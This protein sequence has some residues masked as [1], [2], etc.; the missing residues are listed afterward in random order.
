MLKPTAGLTAKH[1]KTYEQPSALFAL[2]RDPQTNR[3]FAGGMDGAIWV[4][5]GR[6]AKRSSRPSATPHANYLS[7]LA[8]AGD[9]VITGGFDREL[10]WTSLSDGKI[11]RRRHAHEG[12]VRDLAVF[13]DGTKIASAGMTCGSAFGTPRPGKPLTALKAIRSK[14]PRAM[15]RLYTRSPQAQ[16]ENTSPA[17]TA[18]A[19]CG[20]GTPKRGNFWSRSVPRSF[21][22]T[23]PKN[24]S[25][26]LAGFAHWHFPRMDRSWRLRASG[27]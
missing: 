2:A 22:L 5:E 23:I 3:L 14:R 15:R 10:V 11:L 19:K 24:A 8:I 27:R 26:P 16:M 4:L 17:A 7:S 1:Q 9:T 18:S 13:A 6:K 25:A 21:T 20:F 12:W